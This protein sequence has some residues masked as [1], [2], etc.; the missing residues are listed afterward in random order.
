MMKSRQRIPHKVI[1]EIF[2]KRLNRSLVP[3]QIYTH[4]KHMPTEVCRRER[5]FALTLFAKGCRFEPEVYT[6]YTKVFRFL[7]I[8]ISF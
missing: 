1:K 5:Y 2:P 8:M 6:E 3:Q 4:L 7:L